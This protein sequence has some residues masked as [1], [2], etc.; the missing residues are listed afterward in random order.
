MCSA[1][2]FP[3]SMRIKYSTCSGVKSLAEVMANTTSK[4]VVVEGKGEGDED[5]GCSEVIL[6][7]TNGLYSMFNISFFYLYPLA[8]S[9]RSLLTM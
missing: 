5:M 1:E 6:F 2:T 9:L 3:F 8:P 4:K 7:K